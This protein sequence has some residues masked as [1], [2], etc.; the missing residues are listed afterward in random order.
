[1]VI[2]YAGVDVGGNGRFRDTH[3]RVEGPAVIHLAQVFENSLKRA[4][5]D[6]QQILLDQ[7]S[8][9]WKNVKRFADGVFMQVLESD[10]RANK[11]QI[12]RAFRIT[13]ENAQERCYIVRSIIIYSSLV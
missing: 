9:M 1:M 7:K 12:Q 11:W 4:T 5:T 6:W 3:A 8:V 10:V 2:D 13:L